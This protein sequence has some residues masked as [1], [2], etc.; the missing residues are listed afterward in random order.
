MR[1]SQLANRTPAE[2]VALRAA[3]RFAINTLFE[4]DDEHVEA[5]L[6]GWNDECPPSASDLACDDDVDAQLWL[7]ARISASCTA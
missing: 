4:F 2:L 6:N 3:D 7:R 1:I 5:W